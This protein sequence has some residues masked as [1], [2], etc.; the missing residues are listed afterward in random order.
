MISGLPTRYFNALKNNINE[1]FPIEI[2]NV[3]EAFNILNVETILNSEE[4]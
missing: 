4:F 1:R 2:L 3:L